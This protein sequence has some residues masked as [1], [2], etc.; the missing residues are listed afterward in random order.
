M[1]KTVSSSGQEAKIIENIESE[2]VKNRLKG[3]L[4]RFFYSIPRVV[5]FLN[6]QRGS[7]QLPEFVSPE[8]V[9][10]FSLEVGKS[11]ENTKVNH[12]SNLTIGDLVKIIE[13]TFANYE[14][15]ITSLDER[16]KRVKIDIEFAGRSTPIDVPIEI[17]QKVHY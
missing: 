9:E 5:S 6:H 3:Q 7:S 17:C 8:L 11:K 4:V 12:N 2:L 13:G 15:K 16:K 1:T 14:G 10:N